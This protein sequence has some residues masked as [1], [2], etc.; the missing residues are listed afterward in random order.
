MSILEAYTGLVGVE[1]LQP[2]SVL[3]I[4]LINYNGH[5]KIAEGVVYVVRT[6]IVLKHSLTPVSSIRLRFLGQE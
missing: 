1:Q 4:L 3:Q 6:L 5:M 2:L